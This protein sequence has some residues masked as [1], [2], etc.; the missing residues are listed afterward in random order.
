MCIIVDANCA[1]LLKA[2]NCDGVPVLNCL[3]RGKGRLFVSTTLLKELNL[4]HLGKTIL[5]LQ[6]AGKITRADDA[7]CTA[8]AEELKLANVLKSNDAHVVA[9]T[10]IT[11]CPIVVSRDKPLHKDLRNRDLLGKQCSIYQNAKHAHLLERHC[12]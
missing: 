3:L 9:L 6:Q 2:D 12:K 4:T 10:I 5:I 7:I 8:K 1:H 11:S